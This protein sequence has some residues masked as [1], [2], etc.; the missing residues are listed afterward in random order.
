MPSHQD[1]LVEF[2][3]VGRKNLILLVKELPY[4]FLILPL[5]PRTR[6]TLR[7][8]QEYIS[9]VISR[10]AASPT[11]LPSAEA[12]ALAERFCEVSFPRRCSILVSEAS[13]G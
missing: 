7:T 3:P 8:V 1:L 13:G 11:I 12:A 2:P 5:D 4:T 9:N 10:D 6:A